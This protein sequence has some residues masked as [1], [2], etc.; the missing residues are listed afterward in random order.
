M[1]TPFNLLLPLTL[2]FYF[3]LAACEKQSSKPYATGPDIYIAD[4]SFK[5]VGYLPPRDFDKIDEM[6]LD[7]LTYLNLA[8]ANPNKNGELVF[9]G[10]SDIKSI[11][12]KGQ[13]A[14]LK[15]YISLAGGGR[16]DTTIW[17]SVLQPGNMN[18]F[19]KNIL[20]YVGE[21]DLDG[22][23]VDIEWNLL[24]YINDRYTAFVLELKSALH[25]RGKGITT[26]LGAT[27]LHESVTQE[28]LEAY[29]F[30]NVMVYDKTGPWRP[31]DIGPHAP[32]SYAL[33]AVSFWMERRNIP[34]HKIILGLPFYGHDFTEP[35][36]SVAFREIIREHVTYAYQD[37]VNIRYYNG[38]PTIVK[39]AA[40][41]KQKLG[42]IM[43]WEISQDTLHS[44]L[45]LLRTI[46]RTI[47]VG[48]CE[49]KTF[50]RDTDGDGLGDPSHPTQACDPPDGYVEHRQDPG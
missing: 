2:G 45:S 34:P 23:D 50:Y 5:V 47:K 35:A 48:N 33:D 25:A 18:M 1:K 36:R 16:P 12:A 26:A 20:D 32:Y 19:V 4:T 39:K 31:D 28:S 10:N 40:L 15:V 30:I 24:P 7:K 37:S 6:E 41:A 21:N 22:V 9:T 13:A 17:K 3:M 43:I 27:R 38:I 42:G 14:G 11:V 29:D 49:A 8:F 46:D 44:D